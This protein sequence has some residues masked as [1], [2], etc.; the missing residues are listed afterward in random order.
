VT[1]IVSNCFTLFQ[2][3]VKRAGI[4]HVTVS[5]V[6]DLVQNDCGIVRLTLIIVIRFIN[7]L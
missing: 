7:I 3:G 1:L 2:L 6:F 4:V 5:F